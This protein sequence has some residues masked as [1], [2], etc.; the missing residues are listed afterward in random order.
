MHKRQVLMSIVGGML[1]V[2]L[3]IVFYS[4][5]TLSVY[6]YQL[7]ETQRAALQESSLR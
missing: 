4:A 5:V 2:L 6:T 3:G 7:E 1:A